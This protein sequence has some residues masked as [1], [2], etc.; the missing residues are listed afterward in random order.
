M[1]PIN[2]IAVDSVIIITIQ[3]PVM[4]PYLSGISA[5]VVFTCLQMLNFNTFFKLGQLRK[6]TGNN[7]LFNRNTLKPPTFLF[8]QNGLICVLLKFLT[9]GSSVYLVYSEQHVESC[10][11]QKC[12]KTDRQ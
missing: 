8:T 6:T 10:G 2:S 12:H 1:D 7:I 11:K 3:S 5:H 9:V 4:V